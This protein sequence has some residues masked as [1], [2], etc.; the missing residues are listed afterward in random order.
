MYVHSFCYVNNELDIGV[1]VVVSASRYLE[2]VSANRCSSQPRVCASLH[3]SEICLWKKYLDILICHPYIV[4][5]G[6]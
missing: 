4:C 3:I 1:I 6:L 2:K 5:I